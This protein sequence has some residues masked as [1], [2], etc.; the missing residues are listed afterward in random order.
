M[1]QK[2]KS[3]YSIVEA[4]EN[5][6][7][8]S[9]T[10]SGYVHNDVNGDVILDEFSSTPTVRVFLD[11]NN[12]GK[13]DKGEASVLTDANGQY[14]FTD[15]PGGNYHI[16]FALPKGFVPVNKVATEGQAL[17]F[18][19]NATIT[20]K[21][22][23]IR[24]AGAPW[25]Q[26]GQNAQHTGIVPFGTLPTSQAQEVADLGSPEPGQGLVYGS[27]L[28]TKY[29]TIIVP[30]DMD[31]QFVIEA[32]SNFP[33][34]MPQLLWSYASNYTAPTDAQPTVFQPVLGPT[35][36]LYFPG[37]AGSIQVIENPDR[38]A[39]KVTPKAY[40]FYGRDKFNADPSAYRASVTVDTPLSV[41]R[42][43]NVY[44]GVM[45]SGA[46][47]NPA[48]IAS[49]LVRLSVG[50]KGTY[51][52]ANVVMGRAPA[53][54]NDEKFIYVPTQSDGAS[55]LSRFHA[56]GLKAAGSVELRDPSTNANIVF[57]TSDIASPTVGPDG[58]VY[59]PVEAD[60]A[61]QNAGNGWVLHF[62][63]NLKKTKLAGAFNSDVTVSIVPSSMVS[64]YHGKS[65][66]FILSKLGTLSDNNLDEIALFDP[67]AST[68]GPADNV[69]VMK[70]IT[71]LP[72][73]AW[74]STSMAVDPSSNSIYVMGYQPEVG[75]DSNN[76]EIGHIALFKWNVS[77]AKELPVYVFLTD[78][79]NLNA[80][81]SP[82]T[83]GPNG[84][85]FA[86]TD[87]L[88]YGVY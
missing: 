45:S 37:N 42:K 33:G 86:I 23:M 66:Y 17:I 61:S 32:F 21:R 46:D 57:G 78:S 58:D 24:Y 22:A 49:S 9:A 60:S 77:S 85:I 15:I 5:R 67:S 7:H 47:N 25:T 26:I 39:A 64:T 43:G 36:K 50:G 70:I 53:L 35:G 88:L 83:A 87:G 71:S 72:N 63:S 2:A 80:D 34:G 51:K 31:G 1:R 65:S 81:Q 73:V 11:Q 16:R 13:L 4:L 19:G 8:L 84:E 12:N 74:L 41:D 10:I 69:Q 68:A 29:G 44:F 56:A 38:M 27:P 48:K 3:L 62:S 18:Q 30:V 28:Y 79:S 52:A 6:T 55:T 59:M 75:T 54:S 82:V 20:A 76:Q 14:Q 40:Y